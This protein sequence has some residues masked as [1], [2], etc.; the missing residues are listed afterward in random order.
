MST[1]V[2][3]MEAGPLQGRTCLDFW[4]ISSDLPG[5]KVSRVP[6][7]NSKDNTNIKYG[8]DLLGSLLVTVNKRQEQKNS[9]DLQMLALGLEH[10]SEANKHGG[11]AGGDLTKSQSYWT[12]LPTC[13]EVTPRH[14][15][16]RLAGSEESFSPS[17]HT[18]QGTRPASATGRLC[19]S[20]MQGHLTRKLDTDQEKEQAE[21]SVSQ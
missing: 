3:S 8:R 10:K 5:L 2:Y 1:P 9:R 21:T 19:D 13:T 6:P 18:Q 15:P 4:G 16:D 17:H 14:P 11:G 7:R 12:R 20:S